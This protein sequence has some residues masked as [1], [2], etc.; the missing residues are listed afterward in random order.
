MQLK[1]LFYPHQ[2]VVANPDFKQDGKLDGTHVSVTFQVTELNAENCVHAE[3]GL[4]TADQSENAP[5]M[6]NMQAFAT[7]CLEPG[8]QMTQEVR[9]MAFQIMV[10]VI[11]ERLAELTSRGPWNIFLLSPLPMSYANPESAPE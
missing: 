5:Y 2:E 8:V 9:S 10:G 1:R 7:F 4:A 6:F 3:L 11:R